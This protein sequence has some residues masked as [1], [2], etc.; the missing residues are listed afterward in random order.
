[1]YICTYTSPDSTRTI[2]KVAISH[3]NIR[4]CV[5]KKFQYFEIT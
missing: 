2:L 3:S 1:M 5:T 4:K